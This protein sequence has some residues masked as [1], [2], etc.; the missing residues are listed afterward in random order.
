MYRVAIKRVSNG[1]ECNKNIKAGIS[2]II[3]CS[4]CPNVSY[5]G[6]IKITR[7]Q[8]YFKKRG[9]GMIKHVRYAVHVVTINKET[10]Q[11]GKATF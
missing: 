10:V 2:P 1:V 7:C 8:L 11:V 6:C 9:P 3:V 4:A 5:A